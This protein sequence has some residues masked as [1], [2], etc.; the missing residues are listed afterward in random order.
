MPPYS[1]KRP[2]QARLHSTALRF[3]AIQRVAINPRRRGFSG[4][5]LVGDERKRR[6]ETLLGLPADTAVLEGMPAYTAT[7]RHRPIGSLTLMPFLAV[8]ILRSL[9]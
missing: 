3:S 8:A 2:R 5:L 9:A 4:S 1:T 6:T 7:R